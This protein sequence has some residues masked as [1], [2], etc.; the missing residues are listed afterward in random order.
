MTAELA[1]I[2][3]ETISGLAHP[4]GGHLAFA[5]LS[6]ASLLS[7]PGTFGILA[8]V[9]VLGFVGF[10]QAP[11]L[12]EEARNPHRTIPGVTYLALGMIAIIYAGASWAMATHA[13]TSR[14]VAAAARQGPG[15]R[16]A[17]LAEVDAQRTRWHDAAAQARA[18]AQDATGELRRRLPETELPRFHDQAPERARAADRAQ[19]TGRSRAAS[20]AQPEPIS[21]DL[22][23]AAE[24]A[25]LARRTLDEREAQAQRDAEL[26]RQRQ[27]DEPSPD[28]WPHRDPGYELDAM[29]RRAADRTAAQLAARDFPTPVPDLSDPRNQPGPGRD[30]PNPRPRQA[31]RDEPEATL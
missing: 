1:V 7:H 18:A 4:A 11:V 8:V 14:V 24:L 28:R 12:A 3:A 29:R 6:P 10:E 9:A 16:E 20:P 25:E 31:E 13:G 27:A 2:V 26:E 19:E 23:R 30:S 22:R 17:V 15:L 21:A 5:A